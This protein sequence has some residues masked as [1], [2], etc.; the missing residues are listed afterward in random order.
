MLIEDLLQNNGSHNT[1]GCIG[2]S[3]SC[4][5][6]LPLKNCYQSVYSIETL[7]LHPDQRFSTVNADIVNIDLTFIMITYQ[8]SEKKFRNL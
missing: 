4:S 1:T 5:T 7:V 2:C 8:V 6:S 3:L